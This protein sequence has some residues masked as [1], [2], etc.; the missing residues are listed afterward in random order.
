MQTINIWNK[1][2]LF[3]KK[4]GSLKIFFALIAFLMVSEKGVS[5]NIKTIN[6]PNSDERRLH[7]GFLIG[8][9]TSGY[10]TK[11]A[12]AFVR[13]SIRFRESLTNMDS[14]TAIDGSYRPGFSLG[15]ILNVKL[16]DYVDF[17][18][19]PQVAFYEHEVI[20]SYHNQEPNHQ[21]L[22]ATQVEFP[23]LLRYKSERRGNS[24]MYLIGGINPSFEAKGK[25]DEEGEEKLNLKDTNLAVEFGFGIDI[26]YPFFKFSPEIRFSK[27]ITNLRDNNN[28]YSLGL[29]RVSMNTV[30]LFLQFSD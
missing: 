29:E 22:E 6:L 16:T 5:Q 15:F 7:Y 26:Y 28:S 3:C 20:Y 24:R 19:V 27:G 8:I 25:N 30:T 11:Y 23:L 17:R 18:F 9:H 14:V 1:L 21:L 2:N 12:P 13:D 4:G 10:Q